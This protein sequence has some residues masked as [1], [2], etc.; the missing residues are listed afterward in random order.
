MQWLD[1]LI[2]PLFWAALVFAYVAA[3]MPGAEAP[4]IATWDK[5]NH[6]IAFLTL[7]LLSALGWRRARLWRIGLLLAFFG[8]AIELSQA[9]PFIHRD[10]EFDDWAADV[11]AIVVGLII[12]A[13][14]RP[15]FDR[16]LRRDDCRPG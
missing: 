16:M 10:A 15:L 1:R 13:L 12:A 4:T 3:V 5:A 8:A 2:K 9:I 7:T 6:M 11:A 14:L